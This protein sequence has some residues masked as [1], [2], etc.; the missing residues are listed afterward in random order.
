MRPYGRRSAAQNEVLK[1]Y[2]EVLSLS[3]EFDGAANYDLCYCQ[4]RSAGFDPSVHFAFL[5]YSSDKALLVVCNFSSKAASLTVTI[6]PQ[7]PQAFG[8]QVHLDIPARDFAI[9]RK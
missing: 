2:R 3:K 6:P 9:L 8:S 7:A 1:R 4:D 5:R